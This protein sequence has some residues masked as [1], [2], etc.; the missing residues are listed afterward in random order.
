MNA[1]IW[2]RLSAACALAASLAL[3]A[4]ASAE[5]PTIL[6]VQGVLLS[7]MGYPINADGG[8]PMSFRIYAAPTG[9]AP[10]HQELQVVPVVDGRFLVYLGDA[11]PFDF[12][13][14]EAGDAWIGIS[15]DGGPEMTPR[16]E[17]GTVAYAAWAANANAVE[18]SQIRNRP[19]GLDAGGTTY[20][21]GPGIRIAADVVSLSS[22]GCAPGTTWV[23]SGSA[24]Q[25]QTAGATYT[26]GFGINI[27]PGNVIA[28][29]AGTVGSIARDEAYD[30]PAELIAALG[31]TYQRPLD[32]TCP[33]GIAG[34]TPD[35]TVTCAAA[36][37]GDISAVITPPLSGLTGGALSGDV[38]LGVNYTIVQRRI[39][40]ACGPNTYVTSVGENGI[41]V[42]AAATVATP[43]GTRNVQARIVNNAAC[44]YG[45]RTINEDGTVVCA[46]EAFP[47]NYTA[48][49]GITIAGNVISVN[50]DALQVRLGYSGAS[51]GGGCP[52]GISYIEPAN[53]LVYCT[54]FQVQNK[55]CG[56]WQYLRGYDGNGNPVCGSLGGWFNRRCINFIAQCDD[57][58]TN[59]FTGG[60][61]C[62][63]AHITAS[64]DVFGGIEQFYTHYQPG[65][66][67]NPGTYFP[68]I[69]PRGT[70]DNSDRLLAAS[71][72]FE[73]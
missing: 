40:G 46:D 24:W 23:W 45:I 65:W 63:I 13:I 39:T 57:N 71:V 58:L 44:N 6:P 20:T 35:G 5:V 52:Y 17:I 2:R 15:V 69:Q 10:L 53:G 50:T 25:C 19:P 55:F 11:A 64:G 38:T 36:S 28:L 14:L 8:L 66:A 21:A 16:I 68:G 31:S 67:R 49:T 22:V 34:V 60:N 37:S 72:C 42:C 26:G 51:F 32:R 73:E 30:T 29:D 4:P 59:P 3:T 70:V 48:G 61:R 54:P 62:R 41:P 9:G 12:D 7:D 43:A 1:R 33:S 18:W 47:I 27:E 56:E